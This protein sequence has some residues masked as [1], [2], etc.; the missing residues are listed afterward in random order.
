[1][2]IGGI[3]VDMQYLTLVTKTVPMHPCSRYETNVKIIA[4]QAEESL[5]ARITAAQEH[6]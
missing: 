6:S 2:V 4:F 5:P 1:M 3:G